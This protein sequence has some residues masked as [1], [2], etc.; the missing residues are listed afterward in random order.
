MAWEKNFM[1]K[2]IILLCLL[3][4]VVFGTFAEE[5]RIALVDFVVHSRNPDY[6]FLGKGISEM[7]AVELAKS[8]GISLVEREERV[9]LLNE[10]KFALTGLAEDKQKQIEVGNMLAADHLVFG[11]IVDM[12]PQ[13]LISIRMTEVESGEVVFREKLAERPGSYEYITGYFASAIL[14]H[15]DVRVARSTEKKTDE[16]QEK[17]EEAVVAFSR[18]IEAYDRNEEEEAKKELVEAKKLDPEYEAA[19]VYLEKLVSNTAKFRF[20]PD[21]YYF[22]QNPAMLGGMKRDSFF[23]GATLWTGTFYYMISGDSHY[24]DLGNSNYVGE[25]NGPGRVGYHF[26][27]GSKGWGVGVE[28][29]YSHFSDKYSDTTDFENN[30]VTEGRHYRGGALGIGKKL[31]LLSLGLSA[32]LFQEDNSEWGGD[33]PEEQIDRAA[34]A[35]SAGLFYPADSFTISSQVGWSSA[36]YD[37]INPDTLDTEFGRETPLF[38]QSVLVWALNPGRTFLVMNQVSDFY[39]E[40]GDYYLRLMP[41]AEHYL[42][43]RF[44][45]R[46]GLEGSLAHLQGSDQLGYGGMAGFTWIFP[47]S[48][49]EIDFNINY[50]LRPSR[51]LRGELYPDSL[52][53]LVISKEGIFIDN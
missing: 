11:E 45:L 37:S 53:S 33:V 28:F 19:Q 30:N 41:V 20:L 51:V 16:K 2:K 18:A 49:W 5:K 1:S 50:R 35:L 9:E 38:W 46:A 32:S 7:I 3:L 34:Y 6:E 44:S 39:I 26:P 43:R 12:T 47:E 40:E 8:P 21:A 29:I 25:G 14:D 48:G 31:D 36:T 17:K 23:S 4:I 42:S 24:L 10:I 52:Y 22:Y 15:F 27:V 13:L